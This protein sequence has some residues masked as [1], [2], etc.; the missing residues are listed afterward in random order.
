MQLVQDPSQ[1]NEDNL[2]KVIREASRHF[3]NKK[4]KY[5]KTKTQVLETNSKIKIIRDLFRGI[6]DFK[7]GYPPR[8]NIVKDKKG[9][10]VADSHNILATYRYFAKLLYIHG[11]NYVR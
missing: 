7:K 11:V 1:S 8:T 9:D 4:K 5:M 3:R 6:N 10:L 2:N